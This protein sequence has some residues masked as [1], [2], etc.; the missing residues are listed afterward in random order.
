LCSSKSYHKVRVDQLTRR[1]PLTTHDD[2]TGD[3]YSMNCGNGSRQQQA[4][5]ATRL[6][7]AT[8]AVR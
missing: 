6:A 2:C 3:R 5:A 1:Y 7:A 4:A 8:S